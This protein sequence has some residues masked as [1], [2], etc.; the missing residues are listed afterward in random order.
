MVPTIRTGGYP[1]FNP[2]NSDPS[3]QKRLLRQGMQYQSM[4]KSRLRR[5]RWRTN[6]LLTIKG[7]RGGIRSGFD[8]ARGRQC[9]TTRE[10][11]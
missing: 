6:A 4:D 10:K 8:R 5:D 2:A 9:A 11:V 7:I 3:I 1:T